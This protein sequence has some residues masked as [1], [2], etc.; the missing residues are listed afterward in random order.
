ME[1]CLELVA[2]AALSVGSL[3][4][5]ECTS[6]RL[7]ANVRIVISLSLIEKRTALST[8]RLSA[9]SA[10]V[11]REHHGWI[12]GMVGSGIYYVSY[13]KTNSS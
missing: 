8:V 1:V 11:D 3:S 9:K 2:R 10:L 7:N 13:Y 4:T 5:L 6:S 12:C